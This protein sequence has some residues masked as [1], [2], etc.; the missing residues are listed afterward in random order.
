MRT[1][2]AGLSTGGGTGCATTGCAAG[3]CATGATTAGGA[4]AG[5]VTCATA[6]CKAFAA[7]GGRYAIVCFATFLDG[8]TAPG[9]GTEAGRALGA[10]ALAIGAAG[11]GTPTEMDCAAA[12]T[13]AVEYETVECNDAGGEDGGGEPTATVLGSPCGVG[14]YA[15]V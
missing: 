1:V 14:M 9:G 13:S 7:S 11:A 6:C 3:R 5:C 12:R 10:G 2:S 8:I 4:T 15:I